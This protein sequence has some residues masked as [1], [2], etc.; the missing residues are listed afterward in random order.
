MAG[1]SLTPRDLAP[2]W[3]FIHSSS[4]LSCNERTVIGIEN[5]DVF[6]PLKLLRQS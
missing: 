4:T 6:G 3:D 1:L 2:E 5:I